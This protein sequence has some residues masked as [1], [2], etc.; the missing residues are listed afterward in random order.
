MSIYT[1][2]LSQLGT[3]DLQE[4]L[5]ERAV[6]NSRLE[7]KSLIPGKDDTLKKLSSFAN[8]YGGIMVVGAEAD[9]SDG[10]LKDLPGVDLEAGYK[11]KV[12]QW[13]FDGAS[14]PLVVEVSDPIP[15]PSANGKFCYVASVAENDVAPHFLNGRKGVWVRTD[16]FSARFEAHL[17]DEN[18]L[19]HL[20]DRRRLVRERRERI[21]QRGRDR[22]DVLVAKNHATKSGGRSKSGSLLELTFVPRF[23]SRQLCEQQ[24]LAKEIGG[25]RKAWRGANFPSSRS[26][27]LSQH[28]SAVVLNSTAE[29]NDSM[30][31][32]DVW[33]TLF[34]V[35]RSMGST[36]EPWEFISKNS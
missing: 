17:A 22:F 36:T 12:V 16:E 5:D 29:K 25:T 27:I 19:R 10:R 32:V 26:S 9:S 4:L 1:S 18:E 30:F 3:G 15:A 28:E 2:P 23:P 11:Q 13:C 34:S 24:A 21:L 33:G 7:F 20:F 6:E 31:Q 35:L 14:P 8:T